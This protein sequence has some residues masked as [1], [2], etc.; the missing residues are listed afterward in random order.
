MRVS[1]SN[2][3]YAVATGKLPESSKSVGGSGA[4]RACGATSCCTLSVARGAERPP[5]PV[6]IFAS[7]ML[8]RRVILGAGCF[9]TA[10]SWLHEERKAINSPPTLPA[11]AATV[12]VRSE[13]DP[14][15]AFLDLSDGSKDF[16]LSTKEK[17]RSAR[18]PVVAHHAFGLRVNG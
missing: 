6:G 14:Y 10:T 4:T 13:R 8:T 17:V 16:G 9:R 11:L 2:G 7:P 3:T 18:Q 1:N 12:T 5:A 15:L